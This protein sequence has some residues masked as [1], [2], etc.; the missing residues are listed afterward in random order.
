MMEDE[1]G[2][3]KMRGNMAVHKVNPSQ[4]SSNQLQAKA[5]TIVQKNRQLEG[6]G[7]QQGPDPGAEQ[8]PETTRRNVDFDKVTF[9]RDVRQST[10]KSAVTAKDSTGGR[11]LQSESVQRVSLTARLEQTVISSTAGPQPEVAPE[12]AERTSEAGLSESRPDA[13]PNQQSPPAP[14]QTDAGGTRARNQEQVEKQ[15][16]NRQVVEGYQ[17]AT[18]HNRINR[19]SRIDENI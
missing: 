2:N 10:T 6:G 8:Q 14:Q 11:Q 12:Q 3:L 4:E 7:R 5:P 9:S 18:L 15:I 1:S 17:N 19:G 16:I 13:A